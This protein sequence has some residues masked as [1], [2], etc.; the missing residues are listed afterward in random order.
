MRSLTCIMALALLVHCGCGPKA[1]APSGAGFKEN[2][3]DPQ[4]LARLKGTW[5]VVAIVAAG[6]PVPPER[7]QGIKLQYIFDG[8]KLTV[9]RPDRKD[10]VDT[11]VLDVSSN[12]K[13]M[14]I[15]RSLTQRAAYALEGNRLRLCMMVDDNPNAGY[16]ADLV[17]RES[18]KTDLLTLERH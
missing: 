3:S 2:A 4:E 14:R 10:N 15:N 9:H 17:S 12:P 5:D 7:V 13:K 1:I 16:P 8:D 11:F 18:P 6:K